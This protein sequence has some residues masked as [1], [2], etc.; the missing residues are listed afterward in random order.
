MS[1]LSARSLSI[2]YAGRVVFDDVSLDA[3]AGERLGLVGEN[4]AG[5]STL[6][7]LLAEAEEPD[8]GAVFRHGSLGYLSQEPDL[9]PGT[10]KDAV[11]AALAEFRALEARMRTLEGRMSDGDTAALDEYG[12][13]MAEYERRDGWSADA[14]AARA[15]AGLGLGEVALERPVEELSGG[16]QARLALALALVR[17]PDVLLL[18]EP[19]NH[20]DDDAVRYLEDTLRDHHGVVIAA[21]HDRAFLDAVCT[22]ILDLDPALHTAPDGKPALGPSRYAGTYSDYLRSKAAARLRWEHEHQRWNDD[23]DQARAA[24][25]TGARQVGHTNRARRDNDKFQ[26]HFFGQKVDAAVA[27]RVRDAENRLKE[28]EANPVP[29][30]PRPL[31]LRASMGDVPGDGILISARDAAVP[32]RVTLPALDI[33]ADTRLMVTGP[34]GS[35]KSSMMA[36]LAGALEPAQG[37]VMHARGLRIGWL[38]QS[39]TFPD[40]GLSA[41]AVFAAGREGPASEYQS[42]LARLGLLA[43]SELHT[44]VGR[45]SVGQQR[46]LALA[47]LLTVR[48]QVLL[49]DEPTNHLSLG[50]VEELEEAVTGSRLPVVLVTHDRWARHRWDGDRI[51]LR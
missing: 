1:Q 3:G 9:P 40:P 17:A 51:D 36:V 26:P 22:S 13:L 35:G 31:T 47:R 49:L 16:Q 48:P 19:T 39:G 6:L 24:V 4:G 15:I 18:D 46:R 29:K 34:N 11:D 42:E 7:R 14:R 30:P 21:S 23:V 20:L 41:L 25:R 33:A 50:L 5:K 28:L 32:G 8:T 2:S 12:E 27:R 37:R 45:L 10:V 43:G 44:P 38:P